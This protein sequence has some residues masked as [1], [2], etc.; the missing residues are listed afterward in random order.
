MIQ[1]RFHLHKQ[2]VMLEFQL[3]R[4]ASKMQGRNNSDLAEITMVYEQPVRLTRE[5][6]IEM[7]QQAKH[8]KEKDDW[9]IHMIT[10][11]YAPY[12]D[13]VLSQLD[14]EVADALC[15]DLRTLN[16]HLKM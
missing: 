9:F 12:E 4:F 2:A 14:A 7:K 3:N 16:E 8:L 1:T 13:C 6:L 11:R 15:E 5:I 10:E